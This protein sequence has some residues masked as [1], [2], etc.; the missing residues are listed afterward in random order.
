VPRLLAPPRAPAHLP[1]TSALLAPLLAIS[2]AADAQRVMMAV[3]LRSFFQGGGGGSSGSG[4]SGSVVSA[5]A[6]GMSPAAELFTAT[7]AYPR[8]HG[9]V[10]GARAVLGGILGR[11]ADVTHQVAKRLAG[12]KVRRCVCVCGG[13]GVT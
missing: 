8:N 13:G 6:A 12:L 1:L 7:R 11:V 4:S 10:E 9:E 5:A 2:S 3:G